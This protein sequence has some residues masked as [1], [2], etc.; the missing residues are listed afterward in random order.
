M[1]TILVH[2]HVADPAAGAGAGKLFFGKLVSLIER[3]PSPTVLFLDFRGVAVATG[4]FIRESLLAFRDY[5][6]SS[7]SNIYPIIANASQDIL[8]ELEFM[9]SKMKDAFVVCALDDTGR[10]TDGRIV[11]TLEEK[12]LETLKAVL[13]SGEVDASVL[14]SKDPESTLGVTAWNNR[15]AALAAKRILVENRRGRA[16]QYSPVIEIKV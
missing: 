12:Q 7:Q 15:L 2:Q 14:A 4:S 9:F 16:K 1:R 8:D 6:G 11:G 13:A 5:C 10:A 3:Q